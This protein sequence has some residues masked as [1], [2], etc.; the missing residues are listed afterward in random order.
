MPKTIAVDARFTNC[1]RTTIRVVANYCTLS[2][3]I[4]CTNNKYCYQEEVLKLHL[5]L[6]KYNVIY[7]RQCPNLDN[8]EKH[9]L[10]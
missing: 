9:R 2:E 1:A 4:N 5:Q 7:L 10:Q 8:V 3:A 6:C